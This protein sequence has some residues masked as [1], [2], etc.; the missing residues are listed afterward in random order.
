MSGR[1]NVIDYP[2]FFEDEAMTG[3]L[4]SETNV[5]YT[6]NIG[7]QLVFTGTPTGE[8]FVDGSNDEE[9]W[10]T[11]VFLEGDILASGAAGNHLLSLQGYPFKYIRVRYVFSSG[12]GTLNGHLVSKML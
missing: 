1:K 12:S 5:L 6:D 3:N 2:K 4:V 9:N 8:F 7:I 11:Q 10:S